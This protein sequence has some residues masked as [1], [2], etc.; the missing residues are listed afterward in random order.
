M[1]ARLFALSLATLALV[2]CGDSTDSPASTAEQGYPL[3]LHAKLIQENGVASFITAGGSV[4]EVPVSE[5]VGKPYLVATFPAGFSP[6]NDPPIDQSWGYFPESLEISSTTPA[7]YKNGAYD[8]VFVLYVH[9]PISKEQMSGSAQNAPAAVKGDLASFSIDNSVVH[10]GDPKV[11]LGGL[12]F[13]VSGAET[14]VS[15]ENHTPVDPND[16]K[17]IG[18]SFVNTVMVIP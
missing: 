1:F 12:R 6:G 5:I 2:H 10:E 13:N 7:T 4:I 15:I 3:T 17:Q 14:A 9:T 11:T 16:Q 8:V 18:D